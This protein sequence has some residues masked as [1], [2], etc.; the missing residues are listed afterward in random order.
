[1]ADKTDLMALDVLQSGSDH[2]DSLELLV[3]VNEARKECGQKPIRNNDFVARIKDELAGAGSVQAGFFYL[4]IFI[5]YQSRHTVDKSY[6]NHE[7]GSGFESFVQRY[8]CS[9]HW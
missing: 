1:M 2:I 7:K 6:H 4:H 3:L 5:C 8:I 9:Y